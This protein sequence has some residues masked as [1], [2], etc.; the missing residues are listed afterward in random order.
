MIEAMDAALK[1]LHSQDFPLLVRLGLFRYFF[2]YIHPFYDGNGRTNRFITSYFLKKNFHL[3]LG[4]RLSVYIKRNRKAY[5]KLF[6]EADSEINRGDLTPFLQGFLK[7]L[8]G[9]IENTIGVLKRISCSDMR[10]KSMHWDFMINSWE[11]CI[12]FCCRLLFSMAEGSR[13]LNWLIWWGRHVI[14]FKSVW[15]LCRSII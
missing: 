2:A 6:E 12:T 10:R 3:L 1:I 13:L 15:I 11:R 7:I 14:R 5:Y 4:L 8:L 9:T